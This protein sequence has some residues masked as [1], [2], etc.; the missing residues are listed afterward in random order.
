MRKQFKCKLND[1][2]IAKRE[3]QGI[4]KKKNYSIWLAFFIFFMVTVFWMKNIKYNLKKLK[5]KVEL[6]NHIV[7]Y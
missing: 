5:G 4:A 1:M 6:K 7:Y 2:K 3:L